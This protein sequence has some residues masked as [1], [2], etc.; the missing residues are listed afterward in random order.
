MRPTDTHASPRRT[1]R[2][3]PICCT[4]AYC[5]RVDCT[6]CPN[7]PILSEFKQ[8]I[9]STGAVVTDPIWSPLVYTVPQV[10]P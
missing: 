3:Y 6:G 10:K 9:A 5:G 8:W 4:S 2:V 7:L 1:L